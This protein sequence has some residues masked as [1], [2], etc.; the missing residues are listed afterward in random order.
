MDGWRERERERE[1]ERLRKIAYLL[2]WQS[3]LKA[4]AV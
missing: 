3:F 2:V 4:I 1:R